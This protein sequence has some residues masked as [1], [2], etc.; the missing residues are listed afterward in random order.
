ML[1]L[2]IGHILGIIEL[3]GYT[4]T[5]ENYDQI[6]RMMAY[7]IPLYAYASREER[8]YGVSSEIMEY[9]REKEHDK[10]R[11]AYREE[12]DERELF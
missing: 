7:W 2:D 1:T 12:W 8:I 10:I 11:R 3:A 5:Y 9:L 6:A 4:I